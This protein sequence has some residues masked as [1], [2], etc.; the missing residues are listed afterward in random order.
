MLT[1]ILN[2]FKALFSIWNAL[3]PERRNAV[4]ERLKHLPDAFAAIL[5]G[6]DVDLS[7]YRDLESWEEIEADVAKM[8]TA[9]EP[10]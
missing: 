5:R 8:K 10:K 2:L 1:V 7:Q 9:A 6:D 3:P 4:V